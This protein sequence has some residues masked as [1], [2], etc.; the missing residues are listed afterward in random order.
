MS[1]FETSV[2][3]PGN[4]TAMERVILTAN[5]NLQR[6]LSA[7]YGAPVKVEM[8]KCVRVDAES[9]DR[10]V[11]LVLG[12]KI[13]VKDRECLHA[14]EAGLVGVGQL[15][16]Y[17]NILPSFKLNASGKAPQSIPRSPLMKGRKDG[18]M[19]IDY[20]LWR[21]YELSC[22]KISCHFIECF[23]PGFL[24][25]SFLQQALAQPTLSS[26]FEK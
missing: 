13:V 22:P 23:A 16:R 8:R 18:K 10:E 9:F 2:V 12:N 5:G 11:D 6:I 24:D 21:D 25:D 14:I 20:H 15:F 1:A 3:L 4:Y 19:P 7:Y 17:L 26:S